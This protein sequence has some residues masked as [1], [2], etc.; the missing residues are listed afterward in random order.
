MIE[1][2]AVYKIKVICILIYTE[3]VQLYAKFKSDTILT[4]VVQMI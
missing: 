3:K 4:W 1:F 2:V